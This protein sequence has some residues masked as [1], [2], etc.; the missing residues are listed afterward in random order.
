MTEDEEDKSYEVARPQARDDDLGPSVEEIDAAVRR[1]SA[2]NMASDSEFAPP[3]SR[4]DCLQLLHNALGL[5]PAKHE[6]CDM[7]SR[8]HADNKF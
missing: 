6:C 5:Y 2:V 7:T 3:F 1:V 4:K 8:L